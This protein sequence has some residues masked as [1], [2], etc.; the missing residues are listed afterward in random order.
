MRW[1]DLSSSR[2]V[3]SQPSVRF[4]PLPDHAGESPLLSRSGGEKG[5]RGS[6]AGT[7]GQKVHG[8]PWWYETVKEALM[9]RSVL[10]TL[11][12]RER[13]GRFGRMALKHV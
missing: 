12:E 9:Y 5:L 8:L 3:E 11:W 1:L 7:L 4:Q 2:A 10:W 6:G 13:V